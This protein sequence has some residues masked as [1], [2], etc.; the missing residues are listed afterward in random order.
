MKNMFTVLFV[1]LTLSA[2]ALLPV[3]T[4]AVQVP[5]ARAQLDSYL[6][7]PVKQDLAADFALVDATIAQFYSLLEGNVDMSYLDAAEAVFGS[8]EKARKLEDATARIEEATKAY[9]LAS[10][11]DVPVITAKT[12][13]NV[14]SMYIKLRDDPTAV[15]LAQFVEEV[16]PLALY[17]AKK[18]ALKVATGGVL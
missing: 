7:A 6:P 17:V 5:E 11:T 18:A 1:A 8:V 14:K 16:G 4:T 13:G 9:A 3:A 15:K 10:S 12:W 2:C